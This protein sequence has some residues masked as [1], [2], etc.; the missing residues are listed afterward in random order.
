MEKNVK[1]NVLAALLMATS[2]STAQAS[3]T[4]EASNALL[5]LDVQEAQTIA[6]AFPGGNVQ[7]VVQDFNEEILAPAHTTGDLRADLATLRATLGNA[8]AYNG[9]RTAVGLLDNAAGNGP[10]SFIDG[11]TGSAMPLYNVLPDASF[12]TQNR[13]LL[14]AA[15]N[16]LNTGVNGGGNQNAV[17]GGAGLTENTVTWSHIVQAIATIANHG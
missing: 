17:L 5:G 1:N 9:A 4:E 3:L 14:R 7:T 10:G 11:T 12:E 2:V 15:F 8:A 16:I 13:A 6:T